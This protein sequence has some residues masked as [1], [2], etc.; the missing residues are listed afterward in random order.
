MIFY[1]ECFEIGGEV[2]LC[3]AMIDSHNSSRLF[4]AVQI[5]I[6]KLTSL[7]YFFIISK[8]C[9]WIVLCPARY[10]ARAKAEKP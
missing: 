5:A 1:D 7:D 4:P 6:K 10:L 9:V 2:P 8:K 3:T